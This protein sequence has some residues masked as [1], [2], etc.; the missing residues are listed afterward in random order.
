MTFSSLVIMHIFCLTKDLISESTSQALAKQAIVIIIQ[1]K[2]SYAEISMLA[3]FFALSVLTYFS[4]LIAS[5]SCS[6][7]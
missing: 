4:F 3:Q 5:L 7:K 6:I 2:I 1:I